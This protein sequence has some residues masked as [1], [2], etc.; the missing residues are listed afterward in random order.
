MVKFLDNLSCGKSRHIYSLPKVGLDPEANAMKQVYF[1]NKFPKPKKMRLL[2]NDFDYINLLSV[3]DKSKGK[4]Y[5]KLIKY[6]VLTE[7]VST[8]QHSCLCF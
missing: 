3:K 6:K 2:K 5:F 4:Q 8:Q 1:F 7:L